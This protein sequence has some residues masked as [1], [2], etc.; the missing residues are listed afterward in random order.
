MPM[1]WNDDDVISVDRYFAHQ[2]LDQFIGINGHLRIFERAESA[3]RLS[4]AIL[5]CQ[6]V[7][8]SQEGASPQGSSALGPYICG[9]VEPIGLRYV[10]ICP[11]W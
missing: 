4:H 8:T 6:P 1:Q 2:C 9:T 11:R 5:R 3:W 10:V 7:W